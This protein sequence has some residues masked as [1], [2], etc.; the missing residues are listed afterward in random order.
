M[1][2]FRE[3]IVKKFQQGMSRGDIFRSLK[4][5]GVTEIWCI[6]P[7]NVSLIQDLMTTAQKWD[8]NAP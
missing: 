4:N 3:V 7:L 2:A 5:D 1:K 8:V 6:V